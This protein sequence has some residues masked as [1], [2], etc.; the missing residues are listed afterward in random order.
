MFNLSYPDWVYRVFYDSEEQIPPLVIFLGLWVWG[1][2]M[3]YRLD[4]KE[5]KPKP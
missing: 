4:V 2:W 3:A 5:R 1:F